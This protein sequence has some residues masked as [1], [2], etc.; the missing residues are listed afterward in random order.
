[1]SSLYVELQF[2]NTYTLI[3]V[4]WAHFRHF[5]MRKIYKIKHKIILQAYKMMTSIKFFR[6]IF[7]I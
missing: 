4:E 5:N 1:M 7:L 6:H 3:K 2:L